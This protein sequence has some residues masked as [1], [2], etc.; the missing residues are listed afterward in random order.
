MKIIRI[1]EDIIRNKCVVYQY[2]THTNKELLLFDDGSFEEFIKW[3][4]IPLH[5]QYQVYIPDNH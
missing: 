4:G 2:N 3:Y 5:A 1:T